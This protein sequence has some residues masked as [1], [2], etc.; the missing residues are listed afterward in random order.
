MGNLTRAAGKAFKKGS[1]R[2]HV[3]DW[4]QPLSYVFA[5]FAG[6]VL[7]VSALTTENP[8]PIVETPT[9]PV[10]I[11]GDDGQT[12]T[13]DTTPGG[14]TATTPTDGNDSSV[15]AAAVE[16]ARTATVALFTGVFDDVVVYPGQPQPVVITTWDNPV[17][18]ELRRS[19]TFPDGTVAVTHLV[20][21]DGDGREAPREVTILVI[22]VEQGWAF[23]PG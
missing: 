5:G 12:V 6:I 13:D 20:D 3:P 11:D 7:V 14:G 18:V 19:E 4:F 15:D 21:P 2:A 22:R 17:V 10:I 1:R 23:L 9:G 8:P 16:T